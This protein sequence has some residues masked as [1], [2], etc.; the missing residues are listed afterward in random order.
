MA[1]VEEE[2]AAKELAEFKLTTRH[3]SELR[4]IITSMS[5]SFYQNITLLTYT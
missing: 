4:K 2:A 1:N 5:Y 3:Y